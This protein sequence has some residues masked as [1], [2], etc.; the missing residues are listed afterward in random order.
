[1]TRHALEREPAPQR[2]VLVVSIIVNAVRQCSCNVVIGDVG[3]DCSDLTRDGGDDGLGLGAAN[4]RTIA[5]A[6]KRRTVF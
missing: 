4:Q 3:F 2:G 5:K 6:P 1:M